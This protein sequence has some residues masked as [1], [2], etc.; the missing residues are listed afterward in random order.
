MKGNQHAS[1]GALYGLGVIGAL[2]YYLQHATTL[3]DGLVGIVKGLF[4]P[5]V[6]VHKALELLP[7]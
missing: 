7:L 1:S 4:W 2:V 3:V 6:I 5:A